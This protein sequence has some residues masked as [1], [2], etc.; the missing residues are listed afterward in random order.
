MVFWNQKP[1]NILGTWNLLD[2]H[3]DRVPKQ[4]RLDASSSCFPSELPR[5]CEAPKDYDKTIYAKLHIHTAYIVN[6][7]MFSK[8]IPNSY[9]K[10]RSSNT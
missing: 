3:L 5:A 9:K 1:E 10:G 8:L 6:M 7:N 4:D 2:P